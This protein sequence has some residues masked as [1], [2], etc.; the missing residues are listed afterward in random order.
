[1]MIAGLNALS[2]FFF[3]FLLHLLKDLIMTPILFNSHQRLQCPIDKQPSEGVFWQDINGCKKQI[4]LT[5][6]SA[7][8]GYLKQK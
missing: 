7:N 8:K 5:E 4:A 6:M 3:S 2:E 1:M